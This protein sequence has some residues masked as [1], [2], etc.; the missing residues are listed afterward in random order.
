MPLQQQFGFILFFLFFLLAFLAPSMDFM[1]RVG[2]ALAVG[3]VYVIYVYLKNH[4]TEEKI[5]IYAKALI[6]SACMFLSNIFFIGI[7]NNMKLDAYCGL[8]WQQN[9]AK[10]PV[11]LQITY[12]IYGFIQIWWILFSKELNMLFKGN[13]HLRPYWFWRIY[14]LLA[15]IYL[16]IVSPTHCLLT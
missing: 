16:F 4:K 6:V 8:S 12:I 10:P 9:F 1:L 2:I 3:F 14:W 13:R 11:F 5:A 15:A 7:L